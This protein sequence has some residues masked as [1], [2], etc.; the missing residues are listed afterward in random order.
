M[1]SI[2]YFLIIVGVLYSPWMLFS[3]IGARKKNR[4]RSSHAKAMSSS[5][6]VVGQGFD[7]FED[8]TG[9][10]INAAAK[11]LTVWNG[12]TCKTYAYDAVREWETSKVRMTS[13]AMGFGLASALAVGAANSSAA[14]NAAAATGLFLTVKDIDNS[15]WRISMDSEAVQ[16]RWAEILQ[17]ELK[18]GG[19]AA[20]YK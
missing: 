19:I 1:S 7:H 3:W 2:N 17:Q 13:Q 11:S 14:I 6:I 8:N 18:E 20:S 9:I 16:A 5:G 15:K 12:G 4:L 10:G